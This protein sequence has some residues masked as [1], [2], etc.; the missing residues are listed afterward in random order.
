MTG[1]LSRT[2]LRLLSLPIAFL[3]AIG[4]FTVAK[5]QG[6]LSPLGIESNS[7]DSQVVQAVNR[8]QEVSLVQLV[9]EGI[10]DEQRSQTIL[11]QDIWGS[12]ET[13][14]LRYKFDAKLGI[15][16]EEVSVE[17][18]GDNAY[19]VSVP[20]FRFIG[21]DEPTFEVAVQDNGLLSWI[22]PDIDTAD[23]ITDILNGPAQE[24]YLDSYD[25]LLQAQAEVF[26]ERLIISIDPDADTKFEFRSSP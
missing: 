13:V 15:D 18:T 12:T 1:R 26:Y 8:T 3:V 7:R 2:V 19:L 4:V 20:P 24:E 10:T 9:I 11:G 6:L 22:T 14:Y 25:D 23:M 16:G 17:T 21:Y 5:N